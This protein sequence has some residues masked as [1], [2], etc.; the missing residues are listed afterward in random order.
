[1]LIASAG[2]PC[3]ACIDIHPLVY[4]HSTMNATEISPAPD[5]LEAALAS[6]EWIAN[7][8]AHWHV[9]GLPQCWLV[10]GCIAQT[11]WNHKHGFT[12]TYGL[13][14]LDLVY[15]DAV[16]LSEDGEAAQRERIRRQFPD[17]PVRIDVKNQARV[18]L[19]Y[20]QKFGYPL[21]PYESTLAAIDT[22]PTTSTTIGIQP[23]ADGLNAYASYG[24]G[25]LLA[26]VVR[27]NKTQVQQATYEAK[28]G[29]WHKLWPELRIVPWTES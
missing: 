10:A 29:R 17:L 4:W 6:N 8:C 22:Y 9:L 26:L 5:D 7:L 14:D 1:M 11:Y 2:E 13:D 18:H 20:E 28:V 23:A 24:F 15:F 27:P 3:E 12:A 21:A 16:D 25:D 19:W